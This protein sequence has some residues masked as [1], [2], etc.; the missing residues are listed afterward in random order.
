MGCK[1]FNQMMNPPKY[2]N[3]KEYRACLRD[4][5]QMKCSEIEN[6]LDIDIDEES[7]DELLYDT[8]TVSRGMDQIYKQTHENPLFQKLYIAA[9]G[10]ML[11]ENP[12]IGLSILLCYDYFRLF[13][14]CLVVFLDDSEKFSENL[15]CFQKLHRL[16]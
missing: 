14:D 7:K 15:E 13:Y 6:A 8:V 9:A 4:F 16:L 3:N 12:E 2:T 5:F 11:S 10:Q 1:I